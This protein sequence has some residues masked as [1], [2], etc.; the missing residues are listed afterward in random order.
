MDFDITRPGLYYLLNTPAVQTRI[1]E[2]G[3]AS[4]VCF[5]KGEPDEIIR[6]VSQAVAEVVQQE[7]ST[8]LER[9]ESVDSEALKRPEWIEEIVKGMLSG[10]AI[11]TGSEQRM[12]ISDKVLTEVAANTPRPNTELVRSALI[13][14]DG[15][16]PQLGNEISL[17]LRS[18]D[19]VEWLVSFIKL[20]AINAFYPQLRDFCNTPS[21]DGSPRLRIATT[22]YIGGSC[23]RFRT[24]RS[25]SALIH[26]KLVSMPRLI[27]SIGR[28]GLGPP[29]SDQ[30]TFPL[31][32]FL[33]VWNGQLRFLNRNCLIYG[34]DRRLRLRDVGMIR[35]LRPV[36]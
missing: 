6:L 35:T 31:R 24:R 11:Q 34:S 22:T 30:L 14:P 25:R 20:S 5:E 18:S 9:L 15:K 27:C 1:R 23:S 4:R 21:P 2:L 17:E 7:L 3:I 32:H 13:V 26:R 10:N 29:T 36:R 19:R 8:Q 33:L 12:P 16:S 28:A